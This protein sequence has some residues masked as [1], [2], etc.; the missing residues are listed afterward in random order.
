MGLLFP[1]SFF[2]GLSLAFTPDG[3]LAPLSFSVDLYNP[4]GTLVSFYT[5]LL[6]LTELSGFS[7]HLCVYLLTNRF[8]F[9]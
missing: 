7:I 8:E 5:A 2:F 9:Q 6:S 3:L 4:A 1:L